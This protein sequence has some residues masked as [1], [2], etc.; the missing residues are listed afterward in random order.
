MVRHVKRTPN[1][2]TVTEVE[3]GPNHFSFSRTTTTVF[4]GRGHS[5]SRTSSTS[6]SSVQSS[7]R[8]DSVDEAQI[9][10][11]MD[12]MNDMAEISSLFSRIALGGRRE[13]EG[14]GR[15][16][17]CS[18]APRKLTIRKETQRERAERLFAKEQRAQR[19]LNE[20]ISRANGYQEYAPPDPFDTLG[21]GRSTRRR[22]ESADEM[23][24]ATGY[25]QRIPHRYAT[26]ASS[27][28]GSSNRSGRMRM[29]DPFERFEETLRDFPFA[30]MGA[31]MGA[32][33]AYRP[34]DFGMP[35]GSRAP[36]M[37]GR[38][39]D[40][41][42]RHVRDEFD[43]ARENFER[44]RRAHPTLREAN[45]DYTSEH[46][47]YEHLGEGY[48]NPFWAPRDGGAA[49]A[50]RAQS[51]GHARGHYDDKAERAAEAERRERAKKL[52]KER[53]AKRAEQRQAWVK[54]STA[55]FA[56]GEIQSVRLTFQDIPWPIYAAKGGEVEYIVTLDD[57]CTKN[58]KEFLLDL[59]RDKAE[60]EYEAARKKVLRDAIRMFHPDRWH[61]VLPRVEEA[62]RENVK[63]GVELCSR[64]INDLLS[65]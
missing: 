59:A 3:T 52:E 2:V 14:R 49:R 20:R 63:H 18:K 47:Y 19:R 54:R 26:G 40:E 25:E 16:G 43:A 1:G 65:Q 33:F 13:R 27:S 32:G 62:E 58:V 5:N 30:S 17:S 45:P 36:P 8:H 28:T 50:A 15:C 37:G 51:A 44:R 64:I 57:L 56:T 12:S 21:A 10:S 24:S 9:Q 31:G 4:G 41:Y 46:R 39:D 48:A 35:S 22:A 23:P 38:T 7:S 34:F 11:I 42:V 53:A 60:M 61:R 29:P 6:S 55:L